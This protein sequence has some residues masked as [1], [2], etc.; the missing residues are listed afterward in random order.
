MDYKKHFVKD[1]VVSLDVAGF[2]KDDWSYKLVDARTENDWLE[3]YMIIDKDTG[4]MRQDLT[5]I[6]WLKLR[7]VVKCPYPKV[8]INEIIG[9][10]KEFVELSLEQ[11][12]K[13]FGMLKP[14]VF[15][16]LIKAIKKAD[17]VSEETKN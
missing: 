2:N 3:E 17:G 13:L 7:N 14:S 9:V 8:L 11:R 1:E 16:N 15:T 12:K 5:K 4:E 10:D 6:N